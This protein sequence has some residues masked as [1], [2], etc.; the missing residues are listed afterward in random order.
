MILVSRGDE[1]DFL[2]PVRAEQLEVLRALG[3]PPISTE[4]KG[5]RVVAD[6]LWRAQHYKCCY[7]ETKTKSSFNDVEHYRPKAAADRNPG[8][9]LRHGYWWLAFSWSNLLFSCSSC[10]RSAKNDR[11]PLDHGSTAL[12]HEHEPPGQ[13]IPLLL[14]P[15][16]RENPVVHIEF[17]HRP[18]AAGG[19]TKYWFADARAGSTLGATTIEVCNLNHRDLLDLRGDYFDLVISSYIEA[20]RQALRD[21]N[22]DQVSFAYERAKGLLRSPNQYVAL[23]YDSLRSAID[24]RILEEM[25]GQRWPQPTEVGSP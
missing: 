1:P 13:E 4:I 24:E 17:V 11:F 2:S 25:I 12:V 22:P 8:S 19:R 9:T 23:A 7:C 20:L 21:R 6:V 15:C 3:R 18:H 10:N 16:G 14:D 5:Y